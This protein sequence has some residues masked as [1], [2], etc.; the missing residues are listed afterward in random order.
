MRPTEKIKQYIKNVKIKT[1]PK[2]NQAVLDDLLNRLDAARGAKKHAPQPNIW[3]KIMNNRI[4]KLTT[5]AAAVI[6]VS[7]AIFN[8]FVCPGVTFANVIKP[9]LEAKTFAYDMHIGGEDGPVIH[10]LVSGNRIRRTI[11]DMP[12]MV[13]IIDA[14]AGKILRLDT[15]G[16]NAALI[17]MSG[18]VEKGGRNFIAFVR[19]KINR[20]IADPNV[21]PKEQFERQIDDRKVV[22]Y[23]IDND[24]EGNDHER[25]TILADAKTGIPVQIDIEWGREIFI[26]KNL[27]FNIPVPEEDV[28]LT[29]PAGYKMQKADMD[30]SKLSDKDLI[31]SLRVWA[32]HLRDDGTFPPELLKQ[33][34]IK[35]IPLFREKIGSLPIPNAEKEQMGKYFLQGMFFLQTCYTSQ[36]DFHYAG[37]G[38]KL[39]DAAK[40]IFWYRPKDA[41]TYRV[42][43]GDLSVKEVAPEDLPK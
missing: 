14:G 37:A 41:K 24:L 9:I 5:A 4:T 33:E 20:R 43:Y 10:D 8:L 16:K 23:S 3:R 2:V 7:V 31:E 38:V 29:P 19:E 25:V 21:A 22:S 13:L 42:I 15:V 36:M 27:E 35:Q 30:L 18:E 28:S 17:N 32:T 40:A 26:L 39:G 12:G 6:I 34:F 1:N 11:S